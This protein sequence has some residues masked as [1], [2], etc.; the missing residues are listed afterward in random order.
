MSASLRVNNGLSRQRQ[1][2]PLCR[3]PG[4]K[5]SNETFHSSSPSALIIKLNR[6]YFKLR[7]ELVNKK[8]LFCKRKEGHVWI[9]VTSS[10]RLWAPPF[11]DLALH[12]RLWTGKFCLK[13]LRWLLARTYNFISPI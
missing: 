2:A 11:S 5:V 12:Y 9:V 6:E 8:S 3:D 4:S 1:P 10:S 13:K 7:R